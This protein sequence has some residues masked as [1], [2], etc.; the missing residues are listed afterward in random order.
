[1]VGLFWLN[2]F[3]ITMLIQHFHRASGVSVIVSGNGVYLTFPFFFPM[4]WLDLPAP[5]PAFQFFLFQQ[6]SLV[7]YTDCVFPECM[8]VPDSLLEIQYGQWSES[9]YANHLLCLAV[10]LTRLPPPHFAYH[11]LAHKTRGVSCW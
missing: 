1:M 3:G 6:P 7:Q 9:L 10:Y 2:L 11:M 8:F 4:R 5:P